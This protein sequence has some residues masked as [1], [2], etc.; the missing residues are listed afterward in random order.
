MSP[1]LLNKSMALGNRA[2]TTNKPRQV[3]LLRSHNLNI[4]KGYLSTYSSRKFSVFRSRCFTLLYEILKKH[5]GDRRLFH[6][7]ET[8]MIE[9]KEIIFICPHNIVLCIAHT[10]LVLDRLK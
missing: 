10:G 8:K 2:L 7:K 4:V 5:Y 9:L 6:G 3:L 1:L